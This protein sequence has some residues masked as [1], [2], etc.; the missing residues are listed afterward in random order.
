MSPLSTPA[1]ATTGAAPSIP[2]PKSKETAQAFEAI[3]LRQM[4]QPGRSF[5]LL[6]PQSLHRATQADR[7]MQS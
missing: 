4:P 1:A 3:F 7:H 2:T 5:C 6:L